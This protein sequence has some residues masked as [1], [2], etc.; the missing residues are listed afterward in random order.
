MRCLLADFLDPN[1]SQKT[2]GAKRNSAFPFGLVHRNGL[3]TTGKAIGT[4]I[5]LSYKVTVVF[6]ESLLQ[7]DRG[8]SYKV[9]VD[10]SPGS[11]RIAGW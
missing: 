6:A 3:S 11:Y 10:N 5:G 7:S 1:T 2:C 8:C 9:T 4:I